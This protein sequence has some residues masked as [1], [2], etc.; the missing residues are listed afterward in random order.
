MHDA[1]FINAHA[2]SIKKQ[3]L[4]E[5]PEAAK[6]MQA[7]RKAGTQPTEED[8]MFEEELKGLK[9]K[10]QKAEYSPELEDSQSAKG[11]KR[12]GHSAN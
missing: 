12:N 3:L 2:T 10:Y 7:K 1:C 11:A 6:T 9:Q 4:G 8:K 5:P